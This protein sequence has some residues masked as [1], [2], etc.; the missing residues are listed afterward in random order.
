MARTWDQIVEAQGWNDETFALLLREF[1]EN[2][3]MMPKFVEHLEEVAA[4]EN[5]ESTGG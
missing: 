1:V 2:E 4:A 5:E 3:G